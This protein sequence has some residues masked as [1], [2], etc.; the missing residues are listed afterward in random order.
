MHKKHLKNIAFIFARSGSKGLKGKNIKIFNGKPLIAW[1]IECA[2]QSKSINKVIVSTDCEIIAD[3]ARKY[4]A[5]TP[6]IR[7]EVLSQDSTPELMAWKHAI[8]FLNNELS[9]TFDNFISLPC[10]SPLRSVTDIDESIKTFMRNKPDLLITVTEANRNPYFNMV[11]INDKGLCERVIKSSDVIYNRQDAR[12]V[13]DITTV[14]YIGRP[15]Y[16]MNSSDLLNG[17]IYPFIIPK[18]RS[19][20]IDTEHDF[21]Y[22]EFLL[23]KGR[24]NNG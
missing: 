19:I 17:E 3:I 15:N 5:E 9:I 2:L 13:W 8:T 12:E 21:L 16:I 24:S 1:S 23:G 11:K 6:F 22:A 14:I 18:E 7:P 10:T 4:G 20:D